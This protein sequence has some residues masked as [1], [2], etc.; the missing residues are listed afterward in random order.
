MNLEELKK[1]HGEGNILVMEFADGKKCAFK[2]PS[3]QVVA[4]AMTRSQTNGLAPADVLIENCWL[5]GDA[6]IKTEPGYLV[7]IA[8][9]FDQIIG[10][11]ELDIKNF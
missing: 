3:R 1:K 10:L 11:K 2:K 6:E 8:A 4:L 7:A 5:D 9:K